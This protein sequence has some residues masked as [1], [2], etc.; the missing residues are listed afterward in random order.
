MK[1]M[2]NTITA[3]INALKPFSGGADS[4]DKNSL[5]KHEGVR[6]TFGA[7]DAARQALQGLRAITPEMVTVEV[8]KYGFTI[9]EPVARIIASLFQDQ[10][11]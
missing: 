10:E 8:H 1:E 9:D 7:C 11:G 3:A 4:M 6:A 5:M 2:E